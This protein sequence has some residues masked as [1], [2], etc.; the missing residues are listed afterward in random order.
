MPPFPTAIACTDQTRHHS[1]DFSHIK[2]HIDGSHSPHPT[3]I[4]F[5]TSFDEAA[6]KALHIRGL[7][8]PAVEKFSKQERRCES[9]RAGTSE[10]REA[11]AQ[12]RRGVRK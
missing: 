12:E 4:D 6:R 5:D 1:L 2:F 3:T 8:P 10:W 11:R 7:V 9:T